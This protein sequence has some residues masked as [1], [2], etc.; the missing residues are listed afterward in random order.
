[1][2]SLHYPGLRVVTPARTLAPEDWGE[3]GQV[4]S[5]IA[6]RKQLILLSATADIRRNAFAKLAALSHLGK[7]NRESDIDKLTASLKSLKPQ[8]NG[9][10]DGIIRS[11]VSTSKTPMVG[12]A[13]LYHIPC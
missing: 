12:L 3:D 7:R 6:P 10:L 9:I 5:S 2:H 1:M 4:R 11:V 8:P 13:R